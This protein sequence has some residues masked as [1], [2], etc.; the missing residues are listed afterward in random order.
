MSDSNNIFFLLMLINQPGLGPV[1]IMRKIRE[2]GSIEAAAAG[3]ESDE[4]WKKDYEL[5]QKS[6]VS[7]ISYQDPCYPESLLA[8]PDFPPLLYVMGKLEKV[9]HVAIIGTRAASIYGKEVAMRFGEE[10]AASGI[11]VVSGLA[12]GIDTAAH[13]G[14]LRGGKTAAIVGSGLSNLY[15]R[16]NRVLA[17]KIAEN[18]AVIS[19][20]PMAT[21]PLREHFP[22][23]NRLISGLSLGLCLIES[24][25]KGGSMI[26]MER[27]EKQGKKLFALPGRV[28]WPTFQ[29]NHALLKERRAEL[30]ES[31]QEITAALSIKSPL[32]PKEREKISLSSEERAFLE[33]LPPE[34]KSIEEIAQ[35]TQLP[36]MQLNVLLTRLILKKTMKEF[37][38]KIY[39]KLL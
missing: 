27:G 29:G 6:G 3:L 16:E 8:L 30:V 23:R 28:D 32:F 22:R 15:P 33:R 14:A 36:P 26:T 18:G 31:S 25:L 34:E 2:S 13:M 35:L 10:L 24:P 4:K 21:P 5:V 38:G 7:L 9:P 19:E 37:P 39:K 20:F 11:T 12:R 1:G 17:E